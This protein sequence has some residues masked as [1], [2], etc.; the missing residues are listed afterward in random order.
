MTLNDV[1]AAL[2]ANPPGWIP[3]GLG[4]VTPDAHLLSPRAGV[5][6][7]GHLYDG[8][9]A[10]CRGGERPEALSALVLAISTI[11][12]VRLEDQP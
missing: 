10:I 8:A 6:S 3:H 2:T 12:G 5:G 9:C 4:V 11:L 1:V 7:Q